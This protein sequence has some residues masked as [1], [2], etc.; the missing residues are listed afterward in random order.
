ME[1]CMQILVDAD[2]CPVKEIILSIAKERNLPVTMFI[3]KAHELNDGYSDVITVEKGKD[4]AD[5]ALENKVRNGDVVITQDYK[6]AAIALEKGA[7][8]LNQ[9]GFIYTDGNIQR[10]LHDGH[11]IP[12]E[13]TDGDDDKF[14][15]AFLSQLKQ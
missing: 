2:S 12:K 11:H 15:Q 1:V 13:R 7:R 14:E 9:D 4:S 5:K 3:D 10:I 6:V 8:A